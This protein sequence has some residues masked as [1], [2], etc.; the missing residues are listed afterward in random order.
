MWNKHKKRLIVLGVG[1][2]GFAEGAPLVVDAALAVDFVESEHH[3]YSLEG[4]LEDVEPGVF[5]CKSL[6][7]HHGLPEHVG[8]DSVDTGY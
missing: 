4:V 6:V 1:V 5:A 3:L 7:G 2:V 8:V